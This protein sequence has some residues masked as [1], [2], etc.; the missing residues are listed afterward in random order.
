MKKVE[1]APYHA[2]SQ[3]LAERINREVNKLLRIYTRQLAS[4]D[5]DELLPVL[6][7]ILISMFGF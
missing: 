6:Q 7:F 1:I 3:G 4:V 2:A 5:W